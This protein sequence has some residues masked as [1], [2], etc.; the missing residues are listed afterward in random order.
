MNTPRT[1]EPAT[2]R[3]DAPDLSE[4]SLRVLLRLMPYLRQHAWAFGIGFIGLFAARIFEAMIPLY[5]KMGIDRI[6]DGQTDIAEGAITLDSASAA[7]AYPA[8]VIVACVGAQLVMT[9]LSRVLMRRAGMYT[10][11]DLRNRVYRHLQRQGPSFFATYS[12]GDLMAR[13]INDI[14]LVRQ[15]IA[16]TIRMTV[17]LIFTAIVGFAFM[18]SLSWELTL[19]VL[20]PMPPI[21]VVAYL[22]SRRIY[23]QSHRVQEGFSSL[24]TFVQEN[25][26]GIRTVQAM[27]QEGREVER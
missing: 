2:A 7:L 13:A 20:L 23:V 4:G 17:V 19:A 10:A 18:V 6:A 26:G 1:A 3:R 16:G 14:S 24:S 22:F 25:L 15:V 8:L 11:W 21:A 5:V 12:I 27:A 9:I